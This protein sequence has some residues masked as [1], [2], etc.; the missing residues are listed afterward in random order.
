MNNHKESFMKLEEIG[1]KV[2]QYYPTYDFT[3]EFIDKWHRH[4]SDCPLK[5]NIIQINN[6]NGEVIFGWQIRQDA[7]KLYEMGYFADGDILELGSLNGLSTVILS[8]ANQNSPFKKQIYSVDIFQGNVE[9]TVRNLQSLGLNNDVKTICSDATLSVKQFAKEKKQFSFVFID[10]HHAYDSV[11]GV[12][13]ELK[14]IV[15]KGGFCLFH[16]FNHEG[17][18]DES[19]KDYGVYQAVMDSLSKN[20]FEFYGIYGSTALYRAI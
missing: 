17:N 13:C 10:H 20:D 7:L 3:D 9:S 5:E 2:P 12:C 11:Y 16:D 6:G 14:H 19:N 1:T 15:S 18:S 4:F 8:Q